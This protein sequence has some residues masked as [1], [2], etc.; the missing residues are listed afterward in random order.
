MINRVVEVEDGLF[1]ILLDELDHTCSDHQSA[2]LLL[3]LVLHT[4]SVVRQEDGDW[5]PGSTR[6]QDVLETPL[7]RGF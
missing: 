2:V 1:R 6:P 7:A 4:M 5:E 3:S